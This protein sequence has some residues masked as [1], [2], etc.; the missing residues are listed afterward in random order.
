MVVGNKLEYWASTS[1]SASCGV[2][3]NG[4]LLLETIADLQASLRLDLKHTN[5]SMQV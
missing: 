5:T 3:S 4:F 1:P 2:S